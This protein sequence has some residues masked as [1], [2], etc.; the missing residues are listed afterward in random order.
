VRVQARLGVLA[1]VIWPIVSLARA[2]A[3]Q[4]AAIHYVYDD[5]NRLVAVV[6]Q[7]GNVA[8]Y[9]YDAV[10]NILRIDRVDSA[11]IP[12]AVGITLVSPNSGKVGMSVQIFGRGFSA[13]PAQ[14]SVTFN[15][16]PAAVTESAPN[17]LVTS[18]PAGA[19]TGPIAL[20][21]P[22]GS[23]TAPTPFTVVGSIAID[24]ATATVFPSGS[25]QFNVTEEGAPT[26]PPAR[27]SVNDITGG[28]STVGTISTAGLYTAPEPW[29]LPAAGL[30]VRVTATHTDDATVSASASVTIRPPQ[31]GFLAARGVSVRVAD[32]GP[33]PVIAPGVGV[34]FFGGGGVTAV[35]GPA[36]VAFEPVITS[37]SPS[38][39]PRGAADLSITI[40][41]SGLAGATRVSVL[42]NNIPDPNITVA[43]FA[44]SPE[45]TQATVQL[46]IASTAALGPRVVQIA[47][48]AATSTSA[49]TGGNVFTVQ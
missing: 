12:G 38:S 16:T 9:T 27:W 46:S 29:Q 11:G 20:T 25:Q 3:G 40:T 41:G 17:R 33:R 4:P 22:L 49:G 45:G 8:T 36:A 37:V 48:P 42:L 7:Q 35:A 19:T 21:T 14:N 34:Q 5:L 32:S 1:L 31:R 28:D 13:T 39:G 43:N 23:A 2:A 30:T 24:P 18:V 26:A 47:A 6:D 10:G 44:V 15:G